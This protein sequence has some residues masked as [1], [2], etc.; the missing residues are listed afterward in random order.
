MFQVQPGRRSAS[1]YINYIAETRRKEAAPIPLSIIHLLRCGIQSSLIVY[2]DMEGM[3][4][5]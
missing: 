1:E 5:V 4:N 3:D 2:K